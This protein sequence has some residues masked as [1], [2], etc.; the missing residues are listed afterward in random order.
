MSQMQE[1]LAIYFKGIFK[2]SL[3]YP[4][5]IVVFF[6]VYILFIYDFIKA[7]CLCSSRQQSHNPPSL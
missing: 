3:V 1:F 5:G 6:S 2:F 4:S 7:L